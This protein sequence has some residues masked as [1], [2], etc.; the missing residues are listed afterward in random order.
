[1]PHTFNE[2]KLKNTSIWT[3]QLITRLV[4]F[5]LIYILRCTKYSEPD[6]PDNDIFFFIYYFIIYDNIFWIILWI[7]WWDRNYKEK[8]RELKDSNK[9]VIP[10]N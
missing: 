4:I 2:F 10:V 9:L 6:L 7:F 3:I 8:Y 1:M 5:T